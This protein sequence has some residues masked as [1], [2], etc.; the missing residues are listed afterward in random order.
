MSES[1]KQKA[2]LREELF[3]AAWG[4]EELAECMQWLAGVQENLG[5]DKHDLHLL[6][7]DY[8]C[9]EWFVSK[10]NFVLANIISEKASHIMKKLEE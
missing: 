8:A 4:I 3:Y 7:T 5:G 2:D 6:D 10:I 1:I 9:S